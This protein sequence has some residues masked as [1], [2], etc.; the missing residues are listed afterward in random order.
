MFN[1]RF[2]T[3]AVTV[4]CF[5]AALYFARRHREELRESEGSWFALLGVVLNVVAVWALSVEAY[6]YFRP[7]LGSELPAVRMDAL[8]A[9]Q[10]A[11]SLVWTAYATALMVLGVRRNLS[12]LRWQALALFG[13]TVIKVF[14]FDLSY[15][16]GVYR[17]LSSIVLGLILLAVSFLY[18]RRMAAQKAEG[19]K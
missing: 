9:R 7:H 18:Q 15:L 10:L 13:L 6:E 12:A 2:A 4:A 11:L 17:V 1:E 14:F 3:F 8:L 5:A 19:A 16:S